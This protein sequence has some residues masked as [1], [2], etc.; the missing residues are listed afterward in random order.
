MRTSLTKQ[1]RSA[2][3]AALVQARCALGRR[4]VKI[5]GTKLSGRAEL[6]GIYACL[7]R[8]IPDINAPRAVLSRIASAGGLRQIPDG[9][10]NLLRRKASV[11]TDG[12]MPRR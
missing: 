11:T 10:I 3:S 9:A 4:D 8:T 5:I 7:R 1:R 6:D 2:Q 12:M